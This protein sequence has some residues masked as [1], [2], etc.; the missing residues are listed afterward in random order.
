MVTAAVLPIKTFARAKHRLSEAVG[1]PDR[2]AL[3][4]AMVGD[5]LDALAAR[6]RAR[7]G[8]RRDRRAARR[9]RGPRRGR[10]RSS[11]TATRPASPR[12]PRSAST[13]RS[14][15]GAER[16]LLVPGDCPALDPGEVAALLARARPR[17]R[18]DRARPPRRRHQRAAALAARR[19]R[20]LVRAGLL[21]PPR[22][23]RA[24][25]AGPSCGSPRSARSASTSTRPTTSH[26][27]RDAL[28]A[29]PGRGAARTRALLARML[30]A[31]AAAG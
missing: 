10:R 4:E 29:P 11:T 1:V 25:G 28:A 9:R 24:R 19:D 14:R 8:H 16:V 30:P 18:R 13:R 22:G 2:R 17:G 12:P 20:A 23:A 5:V 27:L 3:A 21:R 26:A 15:P 7:P 31:A 6:R